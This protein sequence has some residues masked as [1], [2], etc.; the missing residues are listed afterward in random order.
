MASNESLPVYK[1]TYDLLTYVYVHTR[2]AERDI[3]HTLVEQMKCELIDIIVLICKA[4]G[5][6]DKLPHIVEARDLVVRVKVRMRLLKDLR[7]I[8]EK[9]FAHCALKIEGVS[10]QL[11]AWQE[12]VSRGNKENG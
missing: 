10:K 4:N 5:T 8:S 6:R 2:N 9:V 11:C 7:Q 12:Y 3:R 1:A